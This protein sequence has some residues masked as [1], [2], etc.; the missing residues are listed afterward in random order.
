ML[1]A[2]GWTVLRRVTWPASTFALP[3]EVIE[4]PVS[5]T[6]LLTPSGQEDELFEGGDREKV[7]IVHVQ[8]ENTSPPDTNEDMDE[9]GEQTV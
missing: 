6:W 3:S 5:V 8:S 2:C 9:E 1:R 4:V 7:P